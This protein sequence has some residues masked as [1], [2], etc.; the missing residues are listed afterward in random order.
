MENIHSL[1]YSLMI[2]TL[3]K[4][5]KEKASL[6]NAIDEIPCVGKKADWAIKWIR[7]KDSCIMTRLMAFVAVEGIF[8]FGIILRP[9]LVKETRNYAWIN[10]R[11]E[12]ISRDE[13]MHL[14]LP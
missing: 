2:D 3:V 4:D 11:N 1:S 14:I 7:D 6:F 9:V 12:L 8:F 5:E 10:T 13:G